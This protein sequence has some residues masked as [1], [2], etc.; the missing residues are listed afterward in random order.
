MP[1]IPGTLPPCD[2]SSLKDYFTSAQ[3]C[4]L[5]GRFDA[6]FLGRFQ[7]H[8]T[9]K[10]LVEHTAWQNLAS[11]P[12]SR[13]SVLMARLR[14]TPSTVTSF[15]LCSAGCNSVILIRRYRLDRHLL[16]IKLLFIKYL[17]GPGTRVTAPLI[18]T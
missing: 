1:S 3:T 17:H 7:D 15:T 16:Q 5:L 10:H 12:K 11:F 8:L 14:P 9:F 13:P 2:N 18:P 6:A 4:H